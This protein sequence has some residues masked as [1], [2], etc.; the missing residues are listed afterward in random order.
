[1][2][3]SSL[4]PLVAK[5]R[6]AARALDC[7]LTVVYELMRAGELETVDAGA[8]KRIVWASLERLARTGWPKSPKKKTKPREDATSSERVFCLGCLHWKVPDWFLSSG[9]RDVSLVSR[10]CR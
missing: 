5:P 8:D 3:E 10:C 9:G 6:T 4:P 7:G 2:N 1:M